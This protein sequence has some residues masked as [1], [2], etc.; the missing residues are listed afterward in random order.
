MGGVENEEEREGTFP[1]LITLAND[2]DLISTFFLR[3]I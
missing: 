1:L 3:A 2:Q